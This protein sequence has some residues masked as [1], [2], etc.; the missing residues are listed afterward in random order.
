M[1]RVRKISEK[2][3]EEKLAAASVGRVRKISGKLEERNTQERRQEEVRKTLEMRRKECDL[4][5][6]KTSSI[7]STSTESLSEE[8]STYL[9][10]GPVEGR[11]TTSS[12]PGAGWT[13]ASSWSCST[14]SQLSQKG[15]QEKLSPDLGTNMGT[16]CAQICRAAGTTCHAKTTGETL[17]LQ[18]TDQC[19]R[20]TGPA[21]GR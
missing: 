19:E 18:L 12:P 7:P 8:D 10:V 14:S 4:S 20:E 2:F 3:E 13:P 17:V 16:L 11:R 5:A 6:S 9:D 15:R 1:G 21:D